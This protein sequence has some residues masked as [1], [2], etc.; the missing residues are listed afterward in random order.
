MLSLYRRIRPLFF[1][2]DPE[3]A[4]ELAIGTLA[5]LPAGSFAVPSPTRVSVA[6]LQFPNAVGLAAG[7]D[8]NA[9][10]LRGTFGLGFGF[11]EIGTV[12][13]V[14]QPGNPKPRLFRLQEDGAIV[15]RMG[16]N[17]DGILAALSRIQAFRK[18]RPDAPPL[19]INVGL[20]KH[21]VDCPE[22]YRAI[23]ARAYPLA[24]YIVVNISSPN[25]PGLRDL[26]RAKNIESVLDHIAAAK[27]EGEE[28][29]GVRKPIFVK[30]APD[31]SDDDLGELAE[32]FLR[33]NTDGVI[34][35]NTTVSRPLTLRDSAQS[36]QG[37]LSGEPLKALA[38]NKL[39]TFYRASKGA[40]PIIACG[41]ISSGEDAFLRI[42]NGA[43]AVQ[44]YTCLI[45]D[46]PGAARRIIGE[47]EARLTQN[48]FSSVEEAR[49]SAMKEKP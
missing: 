37:G 48:G 13:L 38:L 16:F 43:S 7:F 40:V 8:K 22:D 47:L 3:K 45:Y 6:G 49:G 25:T 44:I 15:N 46:G 2:L 12:T 28:T 19:G 34:A 14:S 21:R 23:I 30:I 31:V 20:N 39:R 1:S 26:Q 33:H 29:T 41:G 42:A 5:R 4:H 9:K 24:D 32:A 18:A 10:A 35:G 17:N 27:K 11:V 36:E